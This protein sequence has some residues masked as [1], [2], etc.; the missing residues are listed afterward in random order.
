MRM[1]LQ[2]NFL[3]VVLWIIGVVGAN[4]YTVDCL[5]HRILLDTDVDTDDFFALLYLLKQNRSE[6]EVEAVTISVNAWAD[7]GHAVNQ[8]YDILYMM[9]RDDI[10]V[11]VGGDGGILEDGTILPNVGGYLPIIEQGNTTVGYCRYRQAIPVGRRL[12]IDSNYGI[13][14]AFLPQKFR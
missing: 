11:G 3:V 5:P 9:G 7:A 8:I 12:H 13:R 4:L 10:A 6:F 14:K 2:R 1:L